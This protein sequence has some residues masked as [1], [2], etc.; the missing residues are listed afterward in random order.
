[1]CSEPTILCCKG[2]NN[3][4]NRGCF[5]DEVCVQFGDCCPDYSQTCIKQSPGTTVSPLGGSSTQ[6]EFPYQQSQGQTDIRR[7]ITSLQVCLRSKTGEAVRLE[8]LQN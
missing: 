2:V 6:T 4:C 8:S 5:C 1:G 3:F 7:I